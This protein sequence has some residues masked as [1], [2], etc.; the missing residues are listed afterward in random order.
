MFVQITRAYIFIVMKLNKCKVQILL[1]INLFI[2]KNASGH[3][4]EQF[5]TNDHVVNLISM[6]VKSHILVNAASLAHG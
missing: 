2:K 4:L 5:N 3:S 1:P 6:S